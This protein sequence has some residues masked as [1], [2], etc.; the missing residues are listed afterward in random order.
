MGIGKA[1]GKSTSFT[2][3][4]RSAT[5]ISRARYS[6]RRST[7]MPEVRHSPSEGVRVRE[8]D[9]GVGSL[10][11]LRN[12]GLIDRVVMALTHDIRLD[13]AERVQRRAEGRGI[14]RHVIGDG[15]ERVG[16]A[17]ARRLLADSFPPTS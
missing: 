14:P 2:P 13:L 16:D 17:L 7:T 5:S 9:L 15:V 4:R 1:A 6:G 3:R 10:A 8:R 12:R 11:N